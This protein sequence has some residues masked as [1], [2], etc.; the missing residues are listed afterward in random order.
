MTLVGEAN[1]YVG[2]GMC[3]GEIIIKPT[4]DRKF[5]AADNAIAGNTVMY[6]AT[7]GILF[8]SGRVGER[9]CVRNS[10]GT[11]VVE[12]VGDHGCEYMT[13]GLVVILGSTGKNFGAGMSGGLAFVLDADGDFEQIYNPELVEP[14]PLE[15]EADVKL[16][17]ELIYKHL[18]YTE[19]ERAKEILDDW[20]NY[21]KKFVKVKPRFSP[22]PPP[23]DDDEVEGARTAEKDE[24]ASQTK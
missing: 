17:Q 7:G 13:N 21:R 23:G 9:F 6:G 18:E 4:A 19:S 15:D 1:D 3:D 24:I 5:V 12:G 2:K 10:G 11:A 20:E 16:L 14:V 8:A 22:P